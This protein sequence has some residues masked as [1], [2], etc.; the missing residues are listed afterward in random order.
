MKWTCAVVASCW[1]WCSPGWAQD[2]DGSVVDDAA[3]D[4]VTPH[5]G[6]AG[7]PPVQTDEDD[8]ELPEATEQ[9]EAPAA[10]TRVT[11]PENVSAS[12][13][14]AARVEQVE[15]AEYGASAKV[16][17]A[18][19]PGEFEPYGTGSRLNIPLRELPATVTLVDQ[20]TMRERG[21]VDLQ[22]ALGLMPGVMP[23]WQY[24]GFQHIRVRGFQAF[25]LYDGRR[26]PRALL[27]DSA[28]QGGM[29]DVD[30]VELLR[31]PASVL[32]GYGAV[33][34]VVNLIRK[35]PSNVMRNELDL[36]LGLP[37][38]QRAHVGAQ[39]PLGSMLSYRVDLGHVSHTNFRGAL[40]RRSQVTAALRF[41]PS[42]RHTANLRIAYGFDHYNTDVGIPTVEDLDHPGTW[43]LPP[44]ARR[45]R[46]YGTR[47]DYLDYQRLE[48]GGDYRF[49]VTKRT[50]IEARGAVT[51]DHYEYLAAETLTYVPPAGMTPAQVER[52]YL[53]FARG[54]LPA[55]GQLELHSDVQTG[56]VA[57]RLLLGYQLDH[58]GGLSDRGD[59]GDAVPGPID[60]VYP[61]DRAPHVSKLQRTAKDHYRQITHGLYAFD[62]MKLLE[63][64]IVSGGMRLDAF[65]NRTRREFVDRFSGDTIPDPATGM[66]RK[67][68]KQRN[69]AVTGQAG[70][71]YTPWSVVTTYVGYSTSF[72]PQIVYP[73]ATSVTKYK[74]ER[75]QQFEGGVRLRGE[76]GGHT[77]EL[78]TAGYFI[79]KKNVLIPK[80]PDDFVQAGKVHS[81]GLDL[82]LRYTAPWLVQLEAGYSLTAAE[83][84]RYISADP[85]T[86]E[87]VSRD[88]NEVDF[89]PR[90]SGTSWLRLLPAKNVGVGVGTRV[91]GKQFA[92]PENRMPLP[93]YALLDAS[94]WFGGEHATFTLSATNVLDEHDYITSVINTWTANPQVT[95]GPGREI[96]GVV[97]LAL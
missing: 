18:A 69:A 95:P 4:V 63:E 78:D 83:Y 3:A 26:D 7:A 31:G 51:R 90:H 47:N 41:A 54:W 96:L 72:M 8:A 94:L 79:Q 57:H 55:V 36:G 82:S 28:P 88:G 24:G 9:A 93:R 91:M 68:N 81:R 70:I 67:A 74:P 71:V 75:G 35:R 84:K 23:T 15:P 56:P 2:A 76:Q 20:R 12:A 29:Y 50:Y 38:Q 32:Y 44:D 17:R 66:E 6:D 53:Y 61:V 64:L 65:R 48:I 58:M 89:A 62:H 39:G 21:V 37:N 80:G 25:T 97:S 59:V 30:R 52:E 1:L 34:G 86:G 40:T 43:R 85:V 87:N 14:V 73:S 16:V 60:F 45:S 19:G 42:R 10:A 46:R 27:A 13:P 33:G 77:A 49:D 22:Q 5:A 92:D 11:V